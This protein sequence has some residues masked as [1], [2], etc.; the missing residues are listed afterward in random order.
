MKFI[1]TVGTI[2]ALLFLIVIDWRTLI[3]PG[4]KEALT[5]RAAQCGDMEALISGQYWKGLA[6]AELETFWPAPCWLRGSLEA[7]HLRQLIMAPAPAPDCRA[8]THADTG[9]CVPDGQHIVGGSRTCADGWHEGMI[10]QCIQDGS[11][12]VGGGKSRPDGWHSD[13]TETGKCTQDGSHSVGAGRT[14]L[15][16]WHADADVCV[17]DGTHAVGNGR[18]CPD[19]TYLDGD[20]C[21]RFPPP[22]PRTWHWQPEDKRGAAEKH[23]DYG[24]PAEDC[25]LTPEEAK[26]KVE[27]WLASPAG[28]EAVRVAR[29]GTDAKEARSICGYDADRQWTCLPVQDWIKQGL[30]EE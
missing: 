18:T 9:R 25:D 26:A 5:G 14:C 27:S 23:C 24:I 13:A 22:P 6:G 29:E 8:G 19:H 30:P 4:I 1:V 16:G 11:H 10:G 12:D 3:K 7:A 17:L 21:I 15:D 28:R 2:V 20:N